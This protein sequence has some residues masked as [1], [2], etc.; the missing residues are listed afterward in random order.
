MGRRAG[1]LG[2]VGASSR[3][4]VE[5]RNRD[6]GG[7]ASPGGAGAGLGVS[8]RKAPSTPDAS[9]TRGV[10]AEGLRISPLSN[11]SIKEEVLGEEAWR[12]GSGGRGK[13]GRLL[14]VGEGI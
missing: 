8:H 14:A 1:K 7:E 13:G 3:L 4:G 5:E 10:R 9:R 2:A 12:P 11:D 6:L